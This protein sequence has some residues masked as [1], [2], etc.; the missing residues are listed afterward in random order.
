MAWGKKRE[1]RAELIRWLC[2]DRNLSS[3]IDPMGI[4]ITAA[5]IGGRLNLSWLMFSF[6]FGSFLVD[7]SK[8]RPSTRHLFESFAW[9]ADAQWLYLLMVTRNL[10]LR[11]G[12]YAEGTVHI[13]GADIASNLD[14]ENGHLENTGGKALNANRASIHRALL[15]RKGFVQRAR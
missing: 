4:Q 14:C 10:Y 7:S 9:T 11:H 8:M 15:L 3:R 1:I 5:R 12:F 13:R 2:V 6:L